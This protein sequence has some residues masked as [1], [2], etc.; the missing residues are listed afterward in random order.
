MV[1][2]RKSKHED[3]SSESSEEGVITEVRSKI[4]RLSKTTNPS[5]RMMPKRSVTQNQIKNKM[6]MIRESQQISEV[7]LGIFIAIV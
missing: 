4:D 1:E 3:P 2:E 7:N 6:T 5:R